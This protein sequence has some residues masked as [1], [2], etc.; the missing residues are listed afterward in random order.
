MQVARSLSFPP[1]HVKVSLRQQRHVRTAASERQ[2][3]ALP[4]RFTAWLIRC[5]VSVLVEQLL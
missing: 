5:S 4:A 3:P 2:N 1:G